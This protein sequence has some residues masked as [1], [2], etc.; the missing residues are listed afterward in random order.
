MET[1]HRQYLAP[2][3]DKYPQLSRLR[4][5]GTIA[6]VD[7]INRDRAGY[8][9]RVG[10]EIRHQAIECGLLLRP[11]G[12]VLYLMLPYCIEEAEL[13]WVYERID[14]VLERVLD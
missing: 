14:R 12:N 8:L 3:A 5:R 1:R 2:L 7:I 10:M 13:G 4:T 9:N 11:L 6:A